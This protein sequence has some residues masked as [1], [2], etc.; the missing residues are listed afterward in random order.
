LV[1]LVILALL[2]SVSVPRYLQS[3]DKAKEVTLQD[4][5]RQTRT[6]LDQFF[7]DT[8]RYPD[9]LNELVEKR[10]LKRLPIDPVTERT[11]TWILLPPVSPTKGEVADIKSGAQGQTQH[12]RRFDEL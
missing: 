6:V 1:V 12:G 10:Y 7:Q 3:L 4:T 9:S 11:D 8:G 2:L 5:L